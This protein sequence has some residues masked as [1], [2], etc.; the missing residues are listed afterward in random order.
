M[1]DG[2][3]VGGR[4]ICLGIVPGVFRGNTTMPKAYLIDSTN[5]EVEM[6]EFEDLAALQALVGGNIEVAFTWPNGDTLY[7]DEEGLLKEAICYFTVPERPD[8]PLAGNGVL[9]GREVEGP[10]YPNGYTNLP[11]TMTLEGLR[12]RVGFLRRA[13]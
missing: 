11:P 9:V 6:V 2:C 3:S 10:D 12:V 13:I 8:Q 5:Y 4:C 1:P 7:V